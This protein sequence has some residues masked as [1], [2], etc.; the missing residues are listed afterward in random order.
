VAKANFKPR[1][2]RVFEEKLA[3][4]LGDARRKPDPGP[5]MVADEAA[6]ERFRREQDRLLPLDTAAVEELFGKFGVYLELIDYAPAKQ[7]EAPQEEKSEA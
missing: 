2:E 7:A 4:L 6:G 3:H 1:A 5:V